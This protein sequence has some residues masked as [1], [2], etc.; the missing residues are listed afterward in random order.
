M[1]YSHF[2]GKRQATKIRKP[3]TKSQTLLNKAYYGDGEQINESIISKP[4]SMEVLLRLA[5]PGNITG[6]GEWSDKWI[7][8][9]LHKLRRR[10]QIP[11]LE[12]HHSLLAFIPA[13]R[14]EGMR[15]KQRRSLELARP[16]AT[17]LPLTGIRQCVW[18][19]FANHLTLDKANSAHTI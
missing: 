12:H 4:R 10:G 5:A 7:K 1:H 18:V 2:F 6:I 19:P 15:V 11:D 17:C 13:L 14:L 3:F 16:K 8:P 9:V